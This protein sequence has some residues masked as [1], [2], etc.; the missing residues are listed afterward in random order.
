MAQ[1]KD[2]S[3][4]FEKHQIAANE[5]RETLIEMQKLSLKESTER[6]LAAEKTAHW[7]EFLKLSETVHSLKEAQTSTS[8]LLLKNVAMRVREIESLI[9]IEPANSIVLGV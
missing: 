6:A 2:I 9:G 4:D 5:Q 1:F 7:A 3:L 8:A